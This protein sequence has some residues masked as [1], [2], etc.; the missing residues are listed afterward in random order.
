MNLGV[1]QIAPY[2]VNLY[3]SRVSFAKECTTFDQGPLHKAYWEQ[4]RWWA[5]MCSVMS[6]WPDDKV[7]ESQ[8][9]YSS[10]INDP[11]QHK[12]NVNLILT[13]STGARGRAGARHAGNGRNPAR[14]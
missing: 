8:R 12:R 3:F 7:L 9:P 2:L 1:S 4:R 6:P 14:S 11:A 5:F 10:M 13:M